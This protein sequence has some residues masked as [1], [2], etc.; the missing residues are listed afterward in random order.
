MSQPLLRAFSQIEDRVRSASRISLFL[1][2]DGTLSWIAAIPEEARLDQQTR[3]TLRKIAR[4]DRIVATV[5]SGRSIED[6]YSRIRLDGLIYAGNHGFEIFG[7]QFRFVEPG[8]VAHREILGRL[9]QDLSEELEPVLGAHVEYKGYTATIHYRQVADRDVPKVERAVRS[10]VASFSA[11]F[12]V[13]S[14]KKIFEIVPRA[15]WHKGMAVEW[16]NEHLGARDGVLSIYL[17]DDTTD[18]DAFYMLS[19]EI[20]IKVGDSASTCARYQ[21]PDPDA[22]RQF[23]EWLAVAA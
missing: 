2:F 11:W 19:D 21:L 16:I 17:G 12:H 15:D 22:V 3:D 6:L 9:S 18:E 1:D 14:G 13:N 4:I 23:L 20:T 8:A 7:R 5:I 10:K